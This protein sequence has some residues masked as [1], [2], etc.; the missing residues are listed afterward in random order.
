M[1]GLLLTGLFVL[2]PQVDLSLGVLFTVWFGATSVLIFVVPKSPLALPRPAILENTLAVLVG[3][4]VCK[5]IPDPTLK[6]V[7]IVGLAFTIMT[8]TRAL[9]PPAGAVAMTA[10]LRPEKADNLGFLVSMTPLAAGRIVLILM[11][12]LY[13]KPRSCA[14][15]FTA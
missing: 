10:D 3:I 11:A 1:V 12:A 13:P 2:S 7:L 15:R 9:N 8:L 5:Q 6:I 4:G 14:I